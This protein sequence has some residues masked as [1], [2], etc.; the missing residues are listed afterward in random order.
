MVHISLSPNLEFDD[1]VAALGR[2]V[3][4]WDWFGHRGAE[5]LQIALVEYFENPQIYLTAS[6]RGALYLI[7]KSLD[8]QKGDEVI[9]QA[10]TCN[11]VANPIIWAGA[12]PIYADIDDTFNIDVLKL[13]KL[14][15]PNTRAFI[16]QHTFG[17]PARVD[18]II[19]IAR[20]HN[21]VV[22]EDCAH[23]LG[24]TY[25]RRK[26][27]TLGDFALFSFGRDKVISSVY[28]GAVSVN[29]KELNAK[30]E[31]QYKKSKKSAVFWSLQQLLHPL[32]TYPMLLTY[33]Y[34]GKYFL[35]LAQKLHLLSLAVS[36]GE[37][38]GD[39]PSFISRKMPNVLAYLAHHQF[40]K[41]DKLNNHR[42]NLA[43]IYEKELS[44]N[45]NF[46]I[47]KNYDAGSIFLRYPVKLHHG[48]S[49]VQIEDAAQVRRDA[50]KKGFVLGDWYSGVIAP[51]GTDLGKMSYAEGMCPTADSS[52]TQIINLPTNISTSQKDAIK[53]INFLNGYSGNN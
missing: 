7:L 21:I 37:R 12:K 11:A 48:A 45:P 33:N 23:A 19:K 41:L 24:A 34:G 13:E 36:K 32:L 39:M 46:K 42:K 8:L 30:I 20:R 27:G 38:V 14:I 18:E 49:P 50:K 47:V 53:I 51:H 6:G 28:G 1:F 3:F 10:F 43:K 4:V 17:I 44:G 9:T 29:T 2:L 16:I 25:K 26:I 35:Y 31:E 52:A 15:T 5:K 40:K 22:I